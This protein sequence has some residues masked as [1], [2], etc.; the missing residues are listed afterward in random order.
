MERPRPEPNSSPPSR[1]WK[2]VE[3]LPR[4]LPAGCLD[5]CPAP[6]TLH[7]P[8]RLDR[9]IDSAAFRRIADRVVD[10]V[11]HQHRQIDLAGAHHYVLLTNEP[12]IQA[13]G[14]RQGHQVLEH[15]SKHANETNRLR[16]AG[17]IC[18]LASASN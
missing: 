2:R 15:L 18:A 9:E 5:Q 13:L 17:F 4:D 11:S 3:D 16:L 12:N 8:A 6:E 10:E 14:R 1:R 7:R